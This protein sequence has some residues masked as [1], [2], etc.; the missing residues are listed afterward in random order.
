MV[1]YEEVRGLPQPKRMLPGYV[2]LESVGSLL[3]GATSDIREA[4][5]R[6]GLKV[7]T[8]GK[9]YAVA[10]EYIAA[11]IGS[12]T[13]LPIPPGGIVQVQRH[14]SSNG[15]KIGYVCLLFQPEG[16]SLPPIIPSRLVA[17]DPHL[18][19]GAILFDMWI[20]NGIDRH[21]ENLGWLEGFGGVLFD[22]DAALLG[23][24]KG[25]AVAE[26]AN[27]KD[28]PSLDGH[29]LAGELRTLE[30]AY[31]WA[32]RFEAVPNALIRESAETVFRLGLITAPERDAVVEFLV[33]RQRRLLAYLERSERLFGKVQAWPLIDE[34]GD[35]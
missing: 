9:P 3:P 7:N 32:G 26:L 1:A 22:H 29:C 20:R 28:Q 13:G 14:P 33:F 11:R 15:P 6:S 21:E 17:A 2:A 24:R 27:A 35:V 10:N 16:D 25:E 30:D 31:E 4:R 12:A 23:F 5:L 34:A 18:C 8:P 19:M